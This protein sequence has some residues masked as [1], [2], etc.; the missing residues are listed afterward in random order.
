VGGVMV[1]LLVP[2]AVVMGVTVVVPATGHSQI[3]ILLQGVAARVR[4]RNDDAVDGSG[5]ITAGVQVPHGGGSWSSLSDRNAKTNFA[6]V[7][8]R[9][10]L[11]KLAH[12]PVETWN[13]KA[14]PT[15]IRHIGP[16]AQDFAAAFGV[17]EDD[18]HITTVDEE[19]VALAAIQGLNQKVE[20]Q[21][22]ELEQ[23]QTE[24][25]ELK[26]RLE[27]L[28]QMINQKIGGDK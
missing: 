24:I 20:E 7:N 15:H 28:E 23:K 10:V 6:A 18:K 22:S 1:T 21:R 12:I 9:E 5:N 14:Q 26:Q 3:G 19:G 13:Y 25:T 4:P 2:L 17:G 27:K 16:M 8:D 11:E